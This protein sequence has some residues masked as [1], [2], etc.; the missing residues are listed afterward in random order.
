[1]PQ[2]TGACSALQRRSVPQRHS[3]RD[4]ANDQETFEA[5]MPPS[6]L[7]YLLSLLYRHLAKNTSV[8]WRRFI[9]VLTSLWS[10]LRRNTKDDDPPS[11]SDKVIRYDLPWNG[12]SEFR[13]GDVICASALPVESQDAI[14]LVGP[15]QFPS[16]QSP[17][18]QPS[19]GSRE[20]ARPHLD[21]ALQPVQDTSETADPRQLGLIDGSP[22]NASPTSYV[23][24]D[25]RL[26]EQGPS[27]GT[28]P[29]QRPELKPIM[30]E[31]IQEQRYK[32]CSAMYVSTLD[33]YLNPYG[34]LRY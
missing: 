6:Q 18:E 25:V 16:P 24:A 17:V 7:A 8:V 1:V 10:L 32:Q 5:T 27:L 28:Y 9:R 14:P 3:V 19:D 33:W 30:P 29:S 22:V 12:A 20:L 13:H 11:M 26:S 34:F 31:R 2:V 21:T 4:S 23:S 15:M